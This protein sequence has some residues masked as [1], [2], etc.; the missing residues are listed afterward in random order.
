MDSACS[1]LEG[2]KSGKSDESGS[3]TWLNNPR[4]YLLFECRLQVRIDHPPSGGCTYHSSVVSSS[5]LANCFV[6]GHD[7]SSSTTSSSQVPSVH[8]R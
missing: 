6:A 3:L 7:A 4:P 2:T 1:I 5:P 8:Y